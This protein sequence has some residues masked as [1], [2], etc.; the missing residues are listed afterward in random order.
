[1][2]CKTLAVAAATTLALTACGV[3]DILSAVVN[4]SGNNRNSE[5]IA[6]LNEQV[7]LEYGQLIKNYFVRDG[8]R[9]PD[10]D[11]TITA[12]K[13]F[14]G[15]YGLAIYNKDNG[16]TGVRIQFGDGS[17]QGLWVNC[18]NYTFLQTDG[19]WREPFGEAAMVVGTVCKLN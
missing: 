16:Q 15:S 1:M 11:I 8:Y 10:S 14:K 4:N 13:W 3:E 2:K 18:G 6:M 5:R 19:V 7:P 17:T 12:S 9:V